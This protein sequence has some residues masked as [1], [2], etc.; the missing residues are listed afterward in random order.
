MIPSGTFEMGSPPGEEGRDGDEGPVHRV[1]IESPFAVGVHEVTFEEWDACAGDGGCNAYRREI[2]AGDAERDRVVF[3][4]WDDARSY[5]AWLSR[6]TGEEYRLLTESEWEYA[7]RA[8]EGA[9]YAWGDTVGSGRANCETCGSRWDD[10]RTAP[11]GSFSPNAFGVHDM[12]GNV[13]EWVEDCWSPSYAGAPGTGRPWTGQTARSACFG[14]G[15]GMT[16]RGTS[17]P[18]TGPGRPRENRA[19]GFGFRVARSLP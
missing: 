9:R 14:A 15:P 3:V 4:S 6:K 18:R 16:S 13:A 10:D 5:V 2:G 17:D 19:P 11:V 7:A 8:G 12:H 1:R